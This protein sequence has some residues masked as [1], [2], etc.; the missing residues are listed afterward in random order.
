M[1]KPKTLVSHGHVVEDGSIWIVRIRT[2]SNY[3]SDEKVDLD[4][5]KACISNEYDYLLDTFRY[6]ITW[7]FFDREDPIY[8]NCPVTDYCVIEPVKIVMNSG[9]LKCL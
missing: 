8:D 2:P 1:T 4:V 5:S 3:N 7:M 9:E 6:Q